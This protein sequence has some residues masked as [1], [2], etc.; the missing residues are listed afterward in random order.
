[1]PEYQFSERH[2]VRIHA[3]PEQVLQATREAT[4]GD[5][6]SLM[7]LLKIRGWCCASPFVTPATFHTISGF[8]RCVYGFGVSD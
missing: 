7:T 3:K 2:S 8:S 6:K 4:W 5:M 1:M